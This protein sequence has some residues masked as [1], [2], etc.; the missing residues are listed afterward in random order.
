[1]VEEKKTNFAKI[2]TIAIAGFLVIVVAALALIFINKKKGNQLDA[3]FFT[4]T[5]KKIVMP[6]GADDQSATQMEAKQIYQVY[7]NE[8]EKI[9][10][11]F[12]YFEFENEEK[13]QKALENEDIKKALETGTYKNYKVNDKYLVLEMPED[14]YNTSTA[15]QI[16]AAAEYFEQI[17]NS[18]KQN[19]SEEYIMQDGDEE[20]IYFIQNE[21]E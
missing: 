19:N 3:A 10:S 11:A 8:G 15:S 13:A 18:V 2:T 12:L 6:I 16:R 20:K 4:S 21:E 9:T 7:N 1:M 5:D 14:N 17:Q